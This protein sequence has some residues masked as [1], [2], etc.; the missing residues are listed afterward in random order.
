M[1][2]YV[3]V[4]G[5]GRIDGDVM[6]SIR[7]M[8]D[9]DSEMPSTECLV[10]LKFP[11]DFAE[12]QARAEGGGSTYGVL[13]RHGFAQHSLRGVVTPS[14]PDVDVVVPQRRANSLVPP[15]VTS[16]PRRG[17]DDAGP[18]T[19]AADQKLIL[20]ALCEQSPH[21]QRRQR[22]HHH[23]RHHPHSDVEP[24]ADDDE[25]FG[26]YE[27]QRRR[28]SVQYPLS[29]TETGHHHHRYSDVESSLDEDE[30]LGQYDRRRRRSAPHPP[31]IT[32]TGHHR[33]HH[34][35]HRERQRRQPS[36]EQH[37]E[38]APRQPSIKMD[39]L[40]VLVRVDVVS[41]SVGNCKRRRLCYNPSANACGWAR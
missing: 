29:V 16:R 27:R 1:G 10:A 26:Q 12:F 24:S 8:E 3:H 39:T 13:K 19:A 25:D 23:H 28:S 31:S 33:H 5:I 17:T 32:K 18:S 22:Y 4:A 40:Q 30:D 36:S 7:G 41:L 9:D 6:S 21:H 35:H 34:H 38:P 20:A 37:L 11:D 15:G 14:D 2:L